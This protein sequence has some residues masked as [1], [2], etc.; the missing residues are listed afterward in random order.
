MFRSLCHRIL[1]RL[2]LTTE[3]KGKQSN[4]WMAEG[5]ILGKNC[6]IAGAPRL[7]IRR[8]ASIR[9][10][11]GV[12]L[13]SDPTS[14]HAGMSFPVT[15][16][17]DRDGAN[18]NIGDGSR[19]HGCCLHAWHS[20]VVGRGCLLAAGC[21]V[22]DAHGHATEPEFAR[23]RGQLPDIPEEVVIGDYSWLCLGAIVLKG[24]R[25]GEGCIVAPY[26]VVLAGDYPPF[27]MLAGAPARVV[28]TVSDGI[29]LPADFPVEKLAVDG[30][31]LH[32]WSKDI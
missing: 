19:L 30:R 6:I 5:L 13:N 29:V 11:D 2:N 16:V 9:C 1:R 8:G 32:R 24:A 26:S 20:I 14:Y 28:R 22:L 23:L 27:S 10:G 3:N 4:D 17:A 31:S 7:N 21:Q 15:L 18:I 12:V 25:I